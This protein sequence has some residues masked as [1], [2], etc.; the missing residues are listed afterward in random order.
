MQPALLEYD[1]IFYSLPPK[2]AVRIFLLAV[3][4]DGK[5]YSPIIGHRQ[6]AVAVLGQD[7]YCVTV[8]LQKL[9]GRYQLWL[10][11]IIQNSFTP[12]NQFREKTD[13]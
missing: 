5:W 2:Y 8:P 6:T 9:F 7:N 1:A 11:E 10:P 13:P 3:M 4:T 12:F